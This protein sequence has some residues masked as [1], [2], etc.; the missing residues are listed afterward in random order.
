MILVAACG[1]PG[2]PPPP[3][4]DN[5]EAIATI[6][7]LCRTASET[8]FEPDFHLVASGVSD[9]EFG[10]VYSTLHGETVLEI[11][12]LTVS[13]DLDLR[14]GQL[15]DAISRLVDNM[16][17]VQSALRLNDGPTALAFVG[18]SPAAM[19]D[20]D[21][22]AD[23][24]GAIECRGASLSGGWYEAAIAAYEAELVPPPVT[25][26]F[27]VDAR[28]LCEYNVEGFFTVPVLPN[29]E[30]L[31]V[32]E[33]DYFDDVDENQFDANHAALM[34]LLRDFQRLDPADD[35]EA[36]DKAIEQL[37][38]AEYVAG[39]FTHHVRSNGNYGGYQLLELID[40]GKNIAASFERLGVECGPYS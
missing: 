15:A 14:V 6:N 35:V 8:A 5:D 16:R 2:P 7:S 10:L 9:R 23:A 22:K 29:G 13:A 28:T 21:V 19:A 37:R 17:D 3:P 4:L 34:R 39:W 18:E 36:F 38:H 33:F 1:D 25:G 31:E 24:I 40:L 27:V 11:H 20:I 26:N 30:P 32:G 12:R